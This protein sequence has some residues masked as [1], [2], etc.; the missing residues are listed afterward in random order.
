MIIFTYVCIQSNLISVM[1][2][3]S[4]EKA[5]YILKTIAHPARLAI[6]DV[7]TR[8][9]QMQV[10]ELCKTLQLEQSVVSHHLINMKIKGLLKATKSGNCVYY[11]LREPNLTQII[12][13]VN[14]CNCTM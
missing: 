10:N 9:E 11:S 12:N 1:D 5:A 3:A 14:N 7:L 13:C 8:N 2:T 4:L 6:I